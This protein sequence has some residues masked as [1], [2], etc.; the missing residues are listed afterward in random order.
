M[1]LE[2]EI[3]EEE[4]RTTL[5]SAVRSAVVFELSRWQLDDYI[6]NSVKAQRQT[7]V[8]AMIRDELNNSQVLRDKITAELERKIRAQLTAVMK[9]AAAQ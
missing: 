2:V 1:K 9:S 6:K 8:D 3:T 4:I 7:I 5:E